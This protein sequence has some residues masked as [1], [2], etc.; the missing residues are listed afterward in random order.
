MV[1]FAKYVA[2]DAVEGRRPLQRN[3]P[4]VY[5]ADCKASCIRWKGLVSG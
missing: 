4:L 3:I 1:G 5:S 2:D